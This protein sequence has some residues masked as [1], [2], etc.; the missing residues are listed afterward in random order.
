MKSLVIQ[1][2]PY[3]AQPTCEIP[4]AVPTKILI[5]TVVGFFLSSTLSIIAFMRYNET[6]VVLRSHH[7]AEVRKLVVEV[8][9]LRQT[10]KDREERLL[11]IE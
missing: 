9:E 11:S 4:K 5:Y 8:Q 2:K 3:S 1:D 6:H 10:I 7:E